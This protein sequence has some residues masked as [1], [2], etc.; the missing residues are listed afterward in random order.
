LQTL[1]L[2]GMETFDVIGISGNLKLRQ[3]LTV[4]AK[5]ADGKVKEFTVTCRIDT[6]AE[7]D[8][9]RHGGILEYVLRQLLQN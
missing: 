7:L 8:Y 5:G 9:Y 4:R 1:G 6:P 2:T 3:D